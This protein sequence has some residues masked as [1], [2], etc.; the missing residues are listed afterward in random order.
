MTFLKNLFTSASGWGKASENPVEQVRLFREDN[1]R[2]QFLTEEEE[3]RLLAHCNAQ[4]KPLV[5]AALHTGLRK[6]ELLSLR[7]GN[8][9][10]WDRLIKVQASYTKISEAHRAPMTETLTATLKKLKMSDEN[11]YKGCND[12]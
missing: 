7:W 6:S 9:D 2:T 11:I 8:I 1:A 10:F 3:S 5:I 12:D 4:L